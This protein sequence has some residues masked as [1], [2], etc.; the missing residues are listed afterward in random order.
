MAGITSA[1]FEAKSLT[2]ISDSIKAYL[3]SAI[4]PT[5]DLSSTSPWGQLVDA[6]A[7]ELAQVW[8][9]GQDNY[10]AK[11][12][13]Q[14]RNADL[15]AL[16]KLRGT[17]RLPAT[18]STAA[19]TITLAA[20]TYA[21]GTLVVNVVGDPTARFSNDEEI[22]VASPTTLT[23]VPFTAES[24]GPLHA[25]AGTLTV[26][27]NPVVG[28]SAPTNPADAVVGSDI[29][30]DT[31]LLLRSDAEIARKG[32]S[33]VDAIR[34]DLI[35][36]GD[37]DFVAVFENDTDVT[38]GE[39][40]PPHSVEAV[41]KS[42]LTDAEIAALVFAAKAGGIQA[43]GTTT[44]SVTDSQGNVHSV[45]FTRTTETPM[46]IWVDV[47]AIAGRWPGTQAVKDALVAWAD[48]N[49]SVGYDLIN[50]RY[51]QLIM[52]PVAFPGAVDVVIKFNDVNNEG[53]A[54]TGNWTIDPR[55]VGLVEGARIFVD[56]TF[57]NA[58][59]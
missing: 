56:T 23:G 58:P 4:S 3:R 8:E 34:A 22:T 55:E 25:A 39:G 31:A 2:E 14:A 13:D 6:I 17:R 21:A 33:T 1:G 49:Q 38:D 29:E 42:G 16:V 36:T 48:E 18:A 41:V 37:F 19:M 11:D 46:Y 44:E 52:D 9:A 32:S 10:T 5:L 57:V 30:S 45:G 53:T 26:V 27:T 51:S 12:I 47:T 24:T 7:N 35:G 54:V 40:R 20:G 50:R 15:D 28:F 59:P 43:Y